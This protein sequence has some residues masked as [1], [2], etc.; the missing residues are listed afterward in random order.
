ML[1]QDVLQRDPATYHL[2]D[3]G[4]AQVEFPPAPADMA[5]LRAQ[6]ATFVCEGAYADTLR[7]ILE[8]FN[9]TLASGADAPAAWISGFYGSGKSLL[10]AMLAALWT[11]IRFDDGARAEGLVPS[12]PADVRAALRE[13]RGNATRLGVGLLVGG[14]T[15]GAGASDPVKAVLGVVLRA[16]GLPATSDLR[17]MLAAL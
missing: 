14:A 2:A 5:R 12:L 15:L 3:G 10:A 17:P 4:V 13:L 8:A 1:N 11:D 6:L 16:V 9:A 7:R